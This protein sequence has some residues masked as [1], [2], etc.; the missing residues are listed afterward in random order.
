LLTQLKVDEGTVVTGAEDGFLRGVSVLPGRV[1]QPLGQH[2]E[3]DSFPI[4]SLS[5]SHCRRFVASSS[6]DSSIKFYDV[7]AFV[8]GRQRAM[9]TQQMKAEEELMKGS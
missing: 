9:E 8:R 5:L 1:L 6:H 4:Q 7:S 2:E 3:D